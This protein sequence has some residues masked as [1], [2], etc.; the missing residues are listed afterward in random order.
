MRIFIALFAFLAVI[1]FSWAADAREVKTRENRVA[2]FKEYIEVLLERHPD[3]NRLNAALEAARNVPDWAYSLENPRLGFGL[4]NLPSDSYS[5]KT[6]AMTQKRVSISQSFPAFGKR[7]LKKLVAEED[8]RIVESITA[9]KRQDLVK[10][11]WILFLKLEY[12]N[13]VKVTVLKNRSILKGFVEVAGVKYSVGTGLQQNVLQ[14]QV[15]LSNMDALL[16]E[17]D[18]RLGS[19]KALIAVMAELPMD[20]DFGVVRAPRLETFSGDVDKLLEKSVSDRPLFRALES[21]IEK[22]GRKVE[23]SKRDRWPDYTVGLAYSQREDNGPVERSDLVSAS[24]TLSIPAWMKTRQNRKIAENLAL[25]EKA[26]QRLNLEKQRVRR[27]IATLLEIEKSKNGL[28]VLYNKGLLLQAVQAVE[29]TFAAYSVNKVD[30]LTLVSNQIA[31]FNYE[32]KR[33]RIDFE[34]QSARVRLKRTVGHDMK[35][36]ASNAE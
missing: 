20:T 22:S 24:L 35:E 19:V 33:D 8:I 7:K 11:A 27:K 34:L 26:K 17:I 16:L 30:F 28:L 18:E 3:L 36:E 1:W 13:N 6:E 12:L 15:E 29:A 2:S 25:Q 32:I 31:L 9:E 10:E 21:E 5:F 4:M 14:A 23:L